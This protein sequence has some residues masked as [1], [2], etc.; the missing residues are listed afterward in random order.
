MAPTAFVDVTSVSERIGYQAAASLASRDQVLTV[1]CLP[2][3]CRGVL[4]RADESVSSPLDIE[5]IREFVRG[6]ISENRPDIYHKLHGEIDR[7]LLPEM[8]DHVGGNQAQASELLGI[9]RAHCEPRSPIWGRCS[10][11]A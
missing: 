4:H 2:A 9:A 1:D 8:L 3:S 11:N 10:K 7:I 6:L 5:N